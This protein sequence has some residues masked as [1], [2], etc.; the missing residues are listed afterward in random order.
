MDFYVE[1]DRIFDAG[2]ETEAALALY[3]DGGPVVFR[4]TCS[5]MGAGIHAS[6]FERVA[7]RNKKRGFSQCA[8]KNI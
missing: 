8:I 1:K 3:V 5:R 7:A 6:A 4:R 2:M